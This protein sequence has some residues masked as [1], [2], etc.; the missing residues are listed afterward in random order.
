MSVRRPTSSCFTASTRRRPLRGWQR[1][2]NIPTLDHAAKVAPA[3][4]DRQAKVAPTNPSKDPPGQVESA[5]KV[6][7]TPT[8]VDPP[9][10]VPTTSTRVDPPAKVPTTPTRVDPPAKVPTTPTRVDPPA[11][12][13]PGKV[14]AKIPS[15]KAK[16]CPCRLVPNPRPSTP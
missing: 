1:E 4:A 9:A 16:A 7:S 11:K 6:P 2:G 13:A 12:T 15:A 8:R 10:K 14:A 5:A 3:M